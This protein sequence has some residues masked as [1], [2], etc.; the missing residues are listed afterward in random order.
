MRFDRTQMVRTVRCL[1][2]AT[3]YLE[4]GLTQQAIACLD[5]IGNP[6]HFSAMAE[7]LRAEALRREQ[8]YEDAA[9]CFENAA[10]MLPAPANKPIWLALSAYHRQTGNTIQAIETLA[11]ARGAY[12]RTARP[13]R[14]G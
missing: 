8:R 6:G 11:F 5:R 7:M 3:G 13:H 4:L 1:S 9:L 12:S 14:S 2:E 10:R